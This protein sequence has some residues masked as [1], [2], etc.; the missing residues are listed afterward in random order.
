MQ[1]ELLLQAIIGETL[2]LAIWMLIRGTAFLLAFYPLMYVFNT[3]N[4]KYFPFIHIPSLS[5]IDKEG[6]QKSNPESAS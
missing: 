5:F 4:R 2:G 6:L 3:I 1:I